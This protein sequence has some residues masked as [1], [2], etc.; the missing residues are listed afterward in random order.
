[1]GERIPPVPKANPLIWR[2]ENSTTILSHGGLKGCEKTS[3][4]IVGTLKARMVIWLAQRW[5][6]YQQSG[7]KKVLDTI[8]S[9][10]AQKLTY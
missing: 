4:L 6:N 9:Y 5:E 7:D 10:N 3:E 8:L 2:S 1:M